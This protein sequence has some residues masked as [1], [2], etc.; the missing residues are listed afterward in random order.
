MLRD[1]AGARR[2]SPTVALTTG[3]RR[4]S[5]SPSARSA[6]HRAEPTPPPTPTPSRCRRAKRCIAASRAR[7]RVA[8]RCGRV[9]REAHATEFVVRTLGHRRA[10]DPAVSSMPRVPSYA[11]QRSSFSGSCT[12]SATAAVA[13]AAVASSHGP[14][15]RAG[16]CAR[17]AMSA[18]GSRYCR[19]ASARAAAT[20]GRELAPSCSGCTAAA[21]RGPARRAAKAAVRRRKPSGT[22]TGT[23]S[24]C[25]FVLPEGSGPA[26][27]RTDTV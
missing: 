1:T 21:A 13:T 2:Q 15:R 24:R 12:V 14:S 19:S 4:S 9:R 23:A 25:A 11:K 26:R 22:G 20:R 3:S 27:P 17:S 10:T 5:T 7:R 8:A 6:A 18:S 16:A